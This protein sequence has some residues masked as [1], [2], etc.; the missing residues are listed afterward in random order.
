MR[1]TLVREPFTRPDYIYERD[2]DAR[3]MLAY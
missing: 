1:P 3:R 2:E